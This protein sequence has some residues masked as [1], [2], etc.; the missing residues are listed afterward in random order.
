MHG[1]QPKSKQ[2]Q[3][4]D[5]NQIKNVGENRADKFLQKEKLRLIR[6]IL[7]IYFQT[8]PVDPRKKYWYGD[9]FDNLYDKG[10]LE[11]RITLTVYENSKGKNHI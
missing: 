11:L 5:K 1:E 8:T 4:G 2:K 3:Y 9:A 10:M 6:E 7:D